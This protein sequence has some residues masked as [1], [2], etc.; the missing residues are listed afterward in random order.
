[1]PNKEGKYADGMSVAPDHLKRTG[2]RLPTE[3]EWDY[4]CRAR[5]DSRYSFGRDVKLLDLYGWSDGNSYGVSHT[6]GELRPNNLGL[7]DMH[8]NAWEWCQ[9]AY[10]PNPKTAEVKLVPDPDG[11]VVDDKTERVLPGGSLNNPPTNLRST[12]RNGWLLAKVDNAVGF[13]VART[14]PR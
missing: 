12:V 1:M 4:S 8:G 6:V 7:S 9:D 14:L 11:G 5:T 10:H 2:Y 3:A 13:R